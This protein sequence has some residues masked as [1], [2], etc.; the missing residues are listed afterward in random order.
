M[1]VV[2]VTWGFDARTDATGSATTVAIGTR[3]FWIGAAIFTVSWKE[4]IP[5]PPTRLGFVGTVSW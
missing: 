3:V 1:V 5:A 4:V 2:G